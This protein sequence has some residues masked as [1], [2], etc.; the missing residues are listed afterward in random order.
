MNLGW[1]VE[2]EKDWGFYSLDIN[3]VNYYDMA[4]APPRER[5]ELARTTITM[6]MAGPKKS[7]KFAIL[8]KG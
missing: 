2:H 3:G 1:K 6:N 4:E 7:A 8:R 5:A